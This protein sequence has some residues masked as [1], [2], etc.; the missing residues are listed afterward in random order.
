MKKLLEKF[1]KVV[2]GS[3]S[4]REDKFNFLNPGKLVDGE[5]EL[6]FNTR[7]Y[8]QY[9]REEVPT[10]RFKIINVFSREEMGRIDLRIGNTDRVVM[11]LGHI[12]Y[13]VHKKYRGNH[14]AARATIL[15]YDLARNHGMSTLWITCNPDNIAS[16]RT[17][18]LAGAEF[19][20][21]VGVPKNSDFYRAGELRKCRYK[22]DL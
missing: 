2:P 15:L 12:G 20:E 22:V 14:Y 3:G 9:S 4:P 13:R 21:I 17:C 7:L 19:V 5:L 8:N 1:S 10:Y 11:Y 6:E 16:R 18:E